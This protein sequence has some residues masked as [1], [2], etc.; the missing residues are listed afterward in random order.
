MPHDLNVCKKALESVG[1]P[2]AEKLALYIQKLLEINE[3]LNL[4]G[5]KTPEDVA[6]KHVCDSFLAWNTRGG[7]SRPIF[8]IGSGG[9]FPGL[10]LAILSPGVPV[11][12]VERIQKKARALQEMVD[13]LGLENQVEVK[14][15]S[16][17]EI[18]PL[19]EDAEFWFRGFLPGPKLAEYFSR[20]FSAHEIGSIVL[21]K[22]PAWGEEKA[23]ILS[24]PKVK[25]DWIERF[26]QATEESYE[27]PKDAGKRYLVFV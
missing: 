12:L 23:S 25:K 3:V 16:F 26:A 18:K 19:P 6:L 4:T 7:L 8:D 20:C 11:T 15:R 10:V 5:A 24:Q 27:L 2:P 14:A 22:G 9:G 17:E 1:V 21:M 13:F